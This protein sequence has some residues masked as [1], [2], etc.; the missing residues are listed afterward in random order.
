MTHGENYQA[1]PPFCVL[2]VE[3]DTPTHQADL[4]PL[5]AREDPSWWGRRPR[6]VWGNSALSQDRLF[7]SYSKFLLPHA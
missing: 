6:L 5:G 4:Q 7:N 1:R 2:R 3:E